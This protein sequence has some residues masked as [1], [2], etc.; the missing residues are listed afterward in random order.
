MLIVSKHKLTVGIYKEN[1]GF[2]KGA[3][4]IRNQWHNIALDSNTSC[5]SISTKVLTQQ[6]YSN[7]LDVLQNY[8]C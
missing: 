8:G 5:K 3:L 7:S 4:K 6:I 1:Y 2:L